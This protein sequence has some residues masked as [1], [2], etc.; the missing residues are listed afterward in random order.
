MFLLSENLPL[1][2]WTKATNKLNDKNINAGND[3]LIGS[4]IFMCIN[5]AIS[6]K[7]AIPHA[8]GISNSLK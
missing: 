2:Y 7:K 3:F 8:E 1:I 6:I 5:I 4:P